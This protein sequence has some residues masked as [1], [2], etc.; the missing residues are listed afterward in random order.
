MKFIDSSRDRWHTITGEDGP[1]VTLTPSPHS[2]L[3]QLQWNGVRHHWPADMPVGVL[4]ANDADIET[5]ADDLPR[6]ALVAL[7]FPK[8]VDGRAYSQARLLRKRLRF[9]GEVRATGEV[10]VDML[11]LMARCGFDA[12]VLRH[13]QS[14]D[15]A[16]RALRFFPGHYQGDVR[17]PRPLFGRPPEEAC[18]NEDF[19][20]AGA[21]I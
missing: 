18:T 9:G 4:F 16:E 3:T 1:M 2:L 11:P 19:V 8:W 10:L 6:L 14:L 21:S 20:H 15:A 13:D 5:L 17:E 7:Q 12:A